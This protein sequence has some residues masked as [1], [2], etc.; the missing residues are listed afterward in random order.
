MID[1]LD[2]LKALIVAKLDVTELL[3]IL[4]MDV[5]TLV[6]FLDEEIEEH[7]TQLQRACR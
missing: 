1:D 7:Y 6:N 3:D 2:E 4:D 5:A